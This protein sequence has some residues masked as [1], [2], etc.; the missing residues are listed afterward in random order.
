[1][2]CIPVEPEVVEVPEE[3]LCRAPPVVVCPPVVEVA[4]PP[5]VPSRVIVVCARAPDASIVAASASISFIAFLPCRLA[6]PKR[7]NGA[8]VP[9]AAPTFRPRGISGVTQAEVPTMVLALGS[10]ASDAQ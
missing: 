3:P 9:T 10:R 4:D 2:D 6:S 8:P 5:L 1:V 7:P